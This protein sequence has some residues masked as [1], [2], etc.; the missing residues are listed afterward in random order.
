MERLFCPK[1]GEAMAVQDGTL[2]CAR[3]EM[4][5]SRALH[6]SLNEVFVAKT[7]RARAHALH[8]GG[9]WFCPGCGVAASTDKEHVRCP[10]CGEYLDE[11]LYALIELHPHRAIGSGRRGI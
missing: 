6:K 7:R 11:F 4:P 10:R 5:L 9:E 8:W 3:G 2:A 1:C